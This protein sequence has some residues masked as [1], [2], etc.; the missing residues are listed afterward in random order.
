MSMP[1]YKLNILVRTVKFRMESEQKTAEEVLVDY[2]KLTAE[3]K[4]EIINSITPPIQEE[5]QVV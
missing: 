4:Q 2:P 5:T 3:E 1:V